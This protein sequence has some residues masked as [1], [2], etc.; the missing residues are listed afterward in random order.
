MELSINLTS[1]DDYN[2]QL[3]KKN[4]TSLAEKECEITKRE[5]CLRDLREILS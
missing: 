5:N 3:E 2:N 1:Y 4:G